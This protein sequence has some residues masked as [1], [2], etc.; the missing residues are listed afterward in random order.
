MGAALRLAVIAGFT[1]WA[2]ATWPADRPD[3]AAGDQRGLQP[4]TSAGD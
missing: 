2:L 4:Q 1:L 3:R